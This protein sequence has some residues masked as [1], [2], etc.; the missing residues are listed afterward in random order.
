MATLKWRV[1]SAKWREPTCYRSSERESSS[2]TGD[3]SNETPTIRRKP[4]DQ[5]EGPAD[6]D[7]APF[8]RNDDSSRVTLQGLLRYH[9][10]R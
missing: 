5:A 10:A 2:R 1:C 9:R 3:Q 7:A 8:A 4:P 6:R